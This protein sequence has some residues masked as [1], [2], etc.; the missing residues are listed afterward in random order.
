MTNFPG[1]VSSAILNGIGSVEREEDM[2]HI[3]QITN[4]EFHFFGNIG[5]CDIH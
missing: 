4:T 5:T 3:F 2:Y 1:E